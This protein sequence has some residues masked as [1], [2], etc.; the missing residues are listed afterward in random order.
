MEDI[1]SVV[2][3]VV[4]ETASAK[5]GQAFTDAGR[6]PGISKPLQEE[7]ERPVPRGDRPKFLGGNVQEPDI[8][9]A[10][11]GSPANRTAMGL[12][13]STG[14][15]PGPYASYREVRPPPAEGGSRLTE[16]P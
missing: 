12:A 2:R 10:G 16:K 9:L 4:A 6:Q 14:S 8:A 3:R 11:E 5:A 7:K 1:G 13:P 15:A